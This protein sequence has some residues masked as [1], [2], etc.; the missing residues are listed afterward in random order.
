VAALGLVSLFTDLSSEMIYPLVP[1]FLTT[2]LGAGPAAL[3]LI[4]GVA[5]TTAS[6]LKLLSGTLADRFRRRKPLVVAGYALSAAARPLMGLA[7]SWGHVLAV[8][9]ADRVGKG[10]RTSPRDALIAA[11]VAPGERGRA[12][13]LQRAMDHLGAVAGPLAAFVLLAAGL[14][15]RALFLLAAVPG[16]AAVAVLLWGVHEARGEEPRR[17]AVRLG[18]AGL[19][20][21]FRRYLA[22]VCLFTLGNASDAFLL[23]RAVEEGIPPAWVPLLWGAFHAVKSSL[24]VPAGILSDRWDRRRVVAAGW[25]VYAAAYAAWGFARGPW[26]MAGLF[27]FYGLFAAATEGTERA[28][29]ADLVPRDRQATGFGWFHL[30]VGLCALPASV[31]FGLLYKWKGAQAAFG[32]SAV[33]ALA[34]C[35]LLLTLDL[36]PPRPR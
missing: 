21:A 22:V 14:S 5:E 8:R 32:T 30:I 12:F 36:R 15:Y 27:L 6:L 29:V 2:V 10:I 33:L 34:A 1:V 19:P 25:L 28:L 9:F 23:L 18:R 20:G 16:A 4:E 17:G 24:S 3:G 11:A 26:W 31:V 13:G 7:A 35:V